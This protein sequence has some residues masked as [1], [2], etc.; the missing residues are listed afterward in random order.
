VGALRR[1]AGLRAWSL[2]AIHLLAESSIHSL[3]S[4]LRKQESSDFASGT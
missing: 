1:V 3:P 2:L 4:F